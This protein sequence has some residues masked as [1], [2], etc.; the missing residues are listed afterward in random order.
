MADD[1]V[2]LPRSSYEELTKIIRAYGEIADTADL[3]EVAQRS[4]VNRTTV[5]ANNGFLTFLGVIQGGRSKRPTQEGQL[6]AAALE[7]EIAEEQERAWQRLIEGNEFLS[8]M[9]SAVRIRR[10]MEASSLA[11]HIAY[12]AGAKKSSTSS[13]GARTVID[14]LRASGLVIEKDD[15]I[16]PAQPTQPEIDPVE[17]ESPSITAQSP[18]S[19][20]VSP[21]GV[22]GS[23]PPGITLNIEL[24][25][26]ASA[27]DID[28]LGPKI[29]QLLKEVSEGPEPDAGT[30][31]GEGSGATD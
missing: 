2:R 27:S 10:G 3:N 22:A 31:N 30:E 1:T 20:S 28:G 29:R 12:S 25:I 5:S 21:I 4:G 17:P 23:T 16:L 7:H 19:V 9:L 26:E 15:R 6:L 8:K 18:Q 13:T 24:R 11:S 14:I